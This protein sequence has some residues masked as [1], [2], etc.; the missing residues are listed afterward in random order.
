VPVLQVW[1]LSSTKKKKKVKKAN[2]VLYILKCHDPLTPKSQN[3][4]QIAPRFSI[5]LIM[6]THPRPAHFP[7]LGCFWC[8]WGPWIHFCFPSGNVCVIG[9][10]F[11]AS[12]PSWF[13]YKCTSPTRRESQ[14]WFPYLCSSVR[15]VCRTEHLSY[16]WWDSTRFGFAVLRTCGANTTQ[17]T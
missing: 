9:K 16:A 17:L 15:N 7:P 3:P 13:H 8:H 11:G 5:S 14:Y 10:G 6:A 12:L 4:K 2:F 1:N